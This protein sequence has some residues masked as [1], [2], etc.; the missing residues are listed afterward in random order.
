MSRTKNSI[1][2]AMVGIIAQFITIFLS[3][4]SR[5]IF[6]YCLGK[7]YLGIQGL[8]TNVLAILSLSELGLGSAIVYSLYKP[9]HNEETHKIVA[10]M[11]FY[12]KAYRIIG[13]V[14]SIL[15]VCAAP[16][17]PFLM[18]SQPN[19]PHF[20]IIYFLFLLNTVTSYFFYAYRS[21]IIQADQKNYVLLIINAAYSLLITVIMAG[22]LILTKNY[23]LYL[24]IQ[25]VLLI[26]KNLIVKIISDKYY[27]F[28]CIKDDIPLN[29]E[30]KH[31][32]KKNIFALSLAKVSNTVL[33]STDNLVISSFIGVVQTGL[34]SNY[35][36]ITNAVSSILAAIFSSLTASIGD[37]NTDSSPSKK[38][39]IF[40]KIFFSSFWIYGFCTTCLWNLLNLFIGKIWFD[41][42]YLLSQH[43]VIAICINLFTIGMLQAVIAFKD[44]CGIFWAGRYRPL[45]GAILNIVLSLLFVQH[46]GIAGVIYGTILSRLLTATWFDPW[47]VFKNVF[48]KSVLYYFKRVVVYFISTVLSV[49]ITQ[50]VCQ[51]IRLNNIWLQFLFQIFACLLIPNTLFFVLFRNTKDFLY[52]KNLLRSYFRRGRAYK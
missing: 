13:F 47:L 22:I 10:I 12:K 31:H 43:V 30:E 28:L 11:Q 51:S 41:T 46:W 9:L 6:V 4:I 23:I 1:K 49:T 48:N 42:S 35:L 27:P 32:I 26:V 15:G 50:F 21:S 45:L 24:L 38:L 5:T 18:K 3:F 20:Y 39:D 25:I 29:P 37:L 33:T 36:M 16:F 44:A 52:F 40:D 8:F 2:N 7:E 14:L 17:L 19:I 34:Y